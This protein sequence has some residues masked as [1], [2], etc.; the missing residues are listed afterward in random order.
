[1]IAAMSPV[2]SVV[3][4]MR[5]EA[6]SVGPLLARL[7]K[8]LDA[9]G[10]PAEIVV[11]DDGSTD[12]TADLLKAARATEPRL[13]IVA[14]SRNFGK[15]VALAAGLRYARGRAVVLMDGDLQHPPEL[16]E[17]L[18]ARWRTGWQMVY[19]VR[20]DR[21]NEGRRRRMAAKLFYAT[22]ARLSS[23][24]LPRGGGDFRLLDRRVVD[25]LNMLPERTR[26]TKGLY[27]WIGFKQTS[28]P[29]HVAE[30]HAGS[31]G[32]S[33]RSLWRFALDGIV[34]FSTLPLRVWTYIGLLISVAAIGYATFVLVSTLIWGVDVPGYPS[35][36][37][38][39]MF[40]AG[41]Q[42]ISLGIIG[43]YIGRVFTEVKRRPL[44]I[45]AEE[46]GFAPAPGYPGEADVPP[47]EL[48][49]TRGTSRSEVRGTR[50]H[51]GT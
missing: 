10:E 38:A 15:E 35:L 1:M 32:W 44:Y 27:A 22:F 37:V 39:I 23:T 40:F 36:I 33:F 9:I 29:Y 45:V 19:A 34:S 47:P 24:D 16:I 12:G 51:Q 11:I 20:T 48:A 46:V 8:V 41:V 3:V 42:L 43:E 2:L 30:R 50:L 7:G 18:V 17:E 49:R 31:S 5:N 25:A 13:K 26:F 6:R 14:F 4:P 28:V 21:K